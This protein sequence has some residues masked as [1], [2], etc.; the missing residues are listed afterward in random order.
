MD[1]INK[2][3]VG[4]AGKQRTLGLPDA[5]LVPAHVRHFQTIA[6]KARHGARQDAEAGHAK[7]FTAGFKKHLQTDADA[8]KRLTGRNKL[9]NGDIKAE[10][11]QILHAIA[12]RTNAWQDHCVGLQHIGW[13]VN[14]AHVGTDS[15]QRFFRAPQVA[16]AVIN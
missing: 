2:T 12:K 8:K 7:R 4:N 16:A 15:R 11:F 9:P 14:D 3:A 1:K 13:L 5:Q 6:G 10:L